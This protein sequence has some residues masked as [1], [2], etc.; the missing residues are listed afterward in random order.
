[1][2]DNSGT[3][4]LLEPDDMSRARYHSA[5]RDA[6]FDVAPV[7]DCAAALHALT[8]T[9]PRLVIAGFDA[10]THDECVALCEQLRTD[11][12]TSGIPI[13]LTSE[14]IDADELRRATGMSVLGLA[15]GP[16]DAR[17]LVSAVRGVLAGGAA[18]QL[19]ASLPAH[20]R[21]TRSG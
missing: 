14:S 20:D 4:L 13:I 3:V 21:H 15:I 11:P 6:G 17:K 7:N 9:V 18:I 5:L 10:Q 16:N 2:S 1:M 8:V 19:R 12:R